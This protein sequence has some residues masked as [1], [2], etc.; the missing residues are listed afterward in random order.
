MLSNGIIKKPTIQSEHGTE[1]IKYA[2]SCNIVTLDVC[3]AVILSFRTVLRRAIRKLR[4]FYELLKRLTTNA[5]NVIYAVFYVGPSQH[6][7]NATA[8]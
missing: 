6:K 2:G 5:N 4:H 3:G 1:F 8:R 7:F